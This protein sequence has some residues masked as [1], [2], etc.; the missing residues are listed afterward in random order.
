MSIPF[1]GRISG[2]HTYRIPALAYTPSG[3]LVAFAEGRVDSAS[4]TGNID[5]VARRSTDGGETW[6]LQ[7]TLISHGDDTAGNPCVVS[8]ADSLILLSCRQ[9]AADTSLSIRTGDSP[10]RRV[11]VQQSL[12]EGIWWTAPTEISAQVRPSWMRHY[13]TGPGN[14]VQLTAAPY[15]GRI[16]VPCWHTR[17]PTGT[18]TGAEQKY[19]G[20]HGIYSD[21][22]GVTWFV[23]Y[24]SSN[25]SGTLNENETALAELFDGSLY[26]NCRTLTEDTQLGN[27]ADARSI[28]GGMTLTKACRA[29]A[30]I[31]LSSVQGSLLALGD[32]RLVFSG[33]LLPDGRAVMGLMVSEDQGVTWET[34]RRISGLPAGYSN[35]VLMG[36]DIGLLYET[37]DW[38][39]YD[40]IEF[41]RVPVA[42]L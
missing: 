18:D 14:G 2:Y 40:R 1:D 23:G 3:A 22:G 5:I 11:Y 9:G 41:M 35:M 32:G 24:S 15:L 39:T 37:G 12:D 8:T 16:V 29:Q 26:I 4:D 6:G 25:P 13:G 19:Y 38:N 21:D 30:C 28:D 17:I 27:R 34:R 20:A 10:P 42:S 33:P 31:P 36:T 7:S